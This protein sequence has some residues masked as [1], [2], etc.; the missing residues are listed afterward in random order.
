M[1]RF[2]DN[3]KVAAKNETSSKGKPLATFKR[4]LK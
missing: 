4:Y 1:E 3:W 2:N